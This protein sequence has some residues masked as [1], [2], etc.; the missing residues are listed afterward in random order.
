VAASSPAA[1]SARAAGRDI[2]LGGAGDD[3]LNGG[4]DSDLIAGG[5]GADAI[6]G[7]DGRDLLFDGDLSTTSEASLRPILDG[8]ATQ[9]TGAPNLMGVTVIADTASTDKLT[10][11]AGVDAFWATAAEAQDEVSGEFLNGVLIP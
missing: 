3:T 6:D 4:A 11:G 8:W 5:L 2:I 9:T 7:G 1:R 10:G